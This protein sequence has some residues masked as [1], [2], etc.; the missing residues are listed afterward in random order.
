M[1]MQANN[2]DIAAMRKRYADL[3]TMEAQHNLRVG[4]FRSIVRD[5][6][7]SCVSDVE[8]DRWFAEDMDYV[9]ERLDTIYADASLVD[10]AYERG[11]IVEEL[12]SKLK[13][14][15]GDLSKRAE[16]DARMMFE[17]AKKWDAAYGTEY[18]KTVSER[19]LNI[20]PTSEYVQQIPSTT[21]VAEP[22]HEVEA[23]RA[24]R[25]AQDAREREVVEN[26]PDY[27]RRR[28]HDFGLGD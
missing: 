17:A 5:G 12:H 27:A 3:S 15:L 20:A 18:A 2:L 22:I 6:A 25:E 7:D 14:A 19:I 21:R 28:A 23:A 10:T 1:T 24:Q 9:S 13:E 26:L 4:A 16:A 11:N 8:A